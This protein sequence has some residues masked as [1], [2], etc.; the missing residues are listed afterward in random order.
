MTANNLKDRLK[1]WKKIPFIGDYITS[2]KTALDLDRLSEILKDLT[3]TECKVFVAMFTDNTDL[4]TPEDC[5]KFFV[6]ESQN[7]K[8]VNINRAESC[9]IA[10]KH[11]FDD[12]RKN[13]MKKMNIESLS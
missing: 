7:D 13:Y 4:S 2:L 3:D 6:V 12:L 11:M 5:L 1:F 8:R 9:N 10:T